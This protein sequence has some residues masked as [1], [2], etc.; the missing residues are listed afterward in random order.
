MSVGPVTIARI[1][2]FAFRAPVKTPLETSFGRMND[3]PAVFIRI[4]DKEG[5][6]G[7]GEVFANWP[8]AGAEHRVRLMEKD[9]AP[10]VT[11][12]A[13]DGPQ[14]LFHQLSDETRIRARQCG[15]PGPF[16][17]VISGLDIALHDLCARRAGLPLH[18]FLNPLAPGDVPVYAS[19][20][21]I[22]EAPEVVSEMRAAGYRNFKV[23]V[24]FDQ[25][26]DIAEV[27]SLSA[28]LEPGETLCADANQAWEGGMAADFLRRT[29]DCALTWLE[30]PLPAFASGEDWKTLAA[31]GGA[32]LAGGENITGFDDFS[33]AVKAGGL[34]VIQ[35]DVIKWGGITGCGIVAKEAMAAGRRYCPHYL[36]GGPGLM[37]SAALLAAVGGDGLL[38]VDAN[39]NPLRERFF[40]GGGPVSGGRFVMSEAPGLGFTHLPEEITPLMTLHAEIS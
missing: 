17:Q 37:A 2:A 32:P 34:Q 9:V 27:L 14:A 26:R 33:A 25:E 13:F 31:T 10:L 35:P 12:R 8:A 29:G 22:R 5:A 7:W 24:G 11:G 6:F 4:E 20:V 39:P 21:H 1:E 3:R 38:E 18:R 23:K 36:G 15:E 40:G 16:A 30:E 19:G 28:T